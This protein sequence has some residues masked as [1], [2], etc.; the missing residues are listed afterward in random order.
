MANETPRLDY[1]TPPARRAMPIWAW[2]LIGVGG[3]AVLL[4]GV[5]LLLG[6][7]LWSGR[8]S[9]RMTMTLGAPAMKAPT[10]ATSITFPTP[11]T[12]PP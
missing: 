4:I 7:L 5:V 12:E 9:S 3:V 1:A 10:T 2:V 11:T 6:A 8:S